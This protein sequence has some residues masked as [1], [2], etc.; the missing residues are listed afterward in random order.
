VPLLTSSD[1]DAPDD[2]TFALR[3]TTDPDP[4][5]ALSPLMID[6]A[7]PI[8]FPVAEPPVTVTEPPSCDAEAAEP[9][10]RLIR[11]P[12]PLVLVPTVMLT[13]PAVPLVADPVVMATHPVFP[14]AE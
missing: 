4:E 12:S 11:L 14:D 3:T 8:P 5:L 13:T 9:A 2:A 6:T 1:P 10:F 7:P